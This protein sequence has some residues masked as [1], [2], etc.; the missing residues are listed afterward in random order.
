MTYDVAT[1]VIRVLALFVAILYA[2]RVTK[3]RQER[4]SVTTTLV[5][6]GSAALVYGALAPFGIVDP[7]VSR[8]VYT[9]VAVAIFIGCLTLLTV[10][11]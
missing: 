4:R 1:L 8:V 11:K 3:G 2:V 10:E 9:G 7:A 6:V 5:V